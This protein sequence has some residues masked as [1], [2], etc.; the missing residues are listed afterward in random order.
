MGKSE[1]KPLSKNN[2]VEVRANGTSIKYEFEYYQNGLTKKI[3][4]ADENDFT[5]SSFMNSRFDLSDGNFNL[6]R[7]RYKN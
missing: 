7:L 4:K 2:T 6:C 1:E 3:M 5:R